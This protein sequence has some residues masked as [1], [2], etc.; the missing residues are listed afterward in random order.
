ML[1]AKCKT[2]TPDGLKFCN[3]CGTS[4]KRPC[5]SCTFENAPAAKFCGQCGIALGGH[6][7]AVSSRGFP[8][9]DV[10]YLIAPSCRNTELASQ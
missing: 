4:F 7:I 5:S 2:E 6:P 10:G 8:D 9:S 1:C 3:E